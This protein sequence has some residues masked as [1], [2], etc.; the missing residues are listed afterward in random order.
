MQKS[1]LTSQEQEMNIIWCQ[2]N[3][4]SS[5]D[6]F[7]LRYHIR[8]SPS[9][10]YL[11]R[12]SSSP[13][14]PVSSHVYHDSA[15]SLPQLARPDITNLSRTEASSKPDLTSHSK[16]MDRPALVRPGPRPHLPQSPDVG[17]LGSSKTTSPEI[18]YMGTPKE[19]P[20]YSYQ[21]ENM[22]EVD[23]SSAFSSHSDKGIFNFDDFMRVSFVLLLLCQWLSD[24]FFPFFI[25]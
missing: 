4:N 8:H 15:P 3:G 11:V 16:P 9:E 22:K 24:L 18:S 1:S 23:Y 2:N 19:P 13:V 20:D 21:K 10:P 12:Q 17:Y 7:F 5:S 25:F 14:P 6:I